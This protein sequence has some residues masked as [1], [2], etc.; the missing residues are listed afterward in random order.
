MTKITPQPSLV[1]DL[2]KFGQEHLLAFWDKLSSDQQSSLEQQLSEIDFAQIDGLSRG[3]EESPDWAA[4]AIHAQSPPA[5]A[6]GEHPSGFTLAEATKAGEQSLAEGKLAMILAAGG[7][8]TRLGFDQ[9]KGLFEIGPL[10]SRTLF[11]M[12]IDRLK[13]LMKRYGHAIPLYIMTSPAT[14]E[15][16]RNYFESVNWLGLDKENVQIF[17]QGT[18]PAVDA[19]TGKILMSATH[20]VALSPNGHGGMLAALHKNGCLQAAR[21]KGVEHFFYCQIDNPM[22]SVCDPTLIGSHLL[23]KSQITTQVVRKR[24]ALEKVGNVVAVDGR[25]RIIEYS[26]LPASA[27]ELTNADG[28]LRLWA[29]NIAVHL[30][31]LEFLAS[32]LDQV[33]ALPFHR[34]F[35]SVAFVRPDGEFEKPTEP[36]AHKFERFIF[37]LLPMA[38]RSLVVEGDAAEVFAPVKNADGAPTDTPAA[39]KQAISALHR[40]WLQSAGVLVADGI[41]VEIHPAWALDANEVKGKILSGTTISSDTYFLD[42]QFK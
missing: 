2:K 39:T 16:T 6:L 18:M 29:G 13:A 8:G 26:D 11:E 1:S 37:D 38:E 21:S 32:M 22:V 28:S 17:C 41:K 10:S 3:T 35:K 12:Q 7:Q 40:Q 4:M 20:Q 23:T 14:D 36:N 42:Q 27:A 31:E 33:E 30:F 15:E 19:K 25:V 5:I 24:F 34:A 9:P